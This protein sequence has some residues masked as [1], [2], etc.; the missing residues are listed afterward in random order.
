[1][2]KPPLRPAPKGNRFA[3]KYKPEY[4]RQAERF[5]QVGLSQG[6]MAAL[7]GVD[8]DTVTNWKQTFPAFSEALKRGQSGRNLSLLSAMYH[9]AITKR[10]PALMIF[11]AKNWL[12]MRDVQDIGLEG[13]A[14]LRIS[15]VPAKANGR[16]NG[17]KEKA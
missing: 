8:P 10:M 3:S 1:M 6:D 15:I 2:S 17:P 9:S 14:P 7:W 16:P 4:V 5:A 11:L 12:G 13:S